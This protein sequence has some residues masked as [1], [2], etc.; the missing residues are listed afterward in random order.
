MTV[1][2]LSRRRLPEWEFNWQVAG[3]TAAM[4]VIQL[5]ALSLWASW[6]IDTGAAGSPTRGAYGDPN[7]VWSLLQVA[8]WVIIDMAVLGAIYLG[9]KRLPGWLTSAIIGGVAM[10]GIMAIGVVAGAIDFTGGLYV[11]GLGGGLVFVQRVL[12]HV[13]LWAITWWNGVAI[14]FGAL[15]AATLAFHLGV[16]PL[17]V[18]V[19][20]MVLLDPIGVTKTGAIQRFAGMAMA[21]NIPIAVIIPER[22]PFDLDAALE[23]LDEDDSEDA[24]GE[25]DASLLGLGDYALP[26]ALCLALVTVASGAAIGGLVGAVGGVAATTGWM[27][28]QTDPDPQPALPPIMAVTSVGIAVGWIAGVIA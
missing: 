18:L 8:K 15:A 25:F 22:I 21:L 9:Y 2:R 14:G 19:G 1:E 28:A 27:S 6:Q 10:F 23:Q 4:V 16:V 13:D 3:F 20:I 11:A 5:L 12:K 7:S 24:I 17:A 26:T